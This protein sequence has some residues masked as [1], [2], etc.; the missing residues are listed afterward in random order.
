MFM[1]SLRS[2]LEGREMEFGSINAYL[3]QYKFSLGGNWS[4]DHGSFDRALNEEQTVWLRVPFDVTRGAVDSEDDYPEAVVRMGAPFVLR[5]LYQ[6]GP[7]AEAVPRVY[8]S[9][10]DQFQDP[11]DKDAQV[12][13]TWVQQ[14][15]ELLS[16]V[17]QGL[18]H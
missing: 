9:L 3:K 5:H 1:I 4:Y 8:G 11:V 13:E 15:S 18:M 14:A 12:D 7:D 16:R 6:E 10:V 2:T 17:E